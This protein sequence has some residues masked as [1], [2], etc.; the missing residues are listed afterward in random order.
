L[1]ADLSVPDFVRILSEGLGIGFVKI[2]FS[3]RSHAGLCEEAVREVVTK[4]KAGVELRDEGYVVVGEVDCTILMVGEF[5]LVPSCSCLDGEF[6][7]GLPAEFSFDSEG[8][9]AVRIDND[10]V[11][12][13]ATEVRAK[14]VV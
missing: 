10:E 9:Y 5:D 8:L 11:G 1:V 12:L 14:R 3:D 4:N 6:V 7:G 13:K 2:G